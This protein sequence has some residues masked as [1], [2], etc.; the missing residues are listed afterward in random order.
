MVSEMNQHYFQLVLIKKGFKDRV[1]CRYSNSSDNVGM[2]RPNIVN[3][4]KTVTRV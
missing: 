1:F 4:F 2:G 3:L